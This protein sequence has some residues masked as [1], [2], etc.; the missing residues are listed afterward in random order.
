MSYLQKTIPKPEKNEQPSA[1][2]ETS[3]E[4]YHC[5]D[6]ERHINHTF[7]SFRVGK[8][9]PNVGTGG[10]PKETN[11]RQKSF[12][13]QTEIQVALGSWYDQHSAH[14]FNDY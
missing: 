5:T 2:Y 12:R 14:C 6:D 7:P 10:D 1:G 11:G 9:S 13:G 4:T 3:Y 8:V